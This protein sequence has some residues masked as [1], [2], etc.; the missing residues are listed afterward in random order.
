VSEHRDPYF[1]P[2][3]SPDY[4]GFGFRNGAAAE[5]RA[6]VAWLR[7]MDEFADPHALAD[8]IDAR[9]HVGADADV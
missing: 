4:Y 1:G 7:A 8:A 3:P 9:T 5:R 2:D 6:V